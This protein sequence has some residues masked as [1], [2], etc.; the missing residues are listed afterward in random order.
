MAI[1]KNL[2]LL[3]LAF[4]ELQGDFYILQLMT[5]DSGHFT[6]PELS[7]RWS[8]LHEIKSISFYISWKDGGLL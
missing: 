7:V 4:T 6:Q 5:G 8:D 1:V 3:W 2:G